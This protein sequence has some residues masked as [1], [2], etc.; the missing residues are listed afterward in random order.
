M[1]KHI[2]FQIVFTIFAGSAYAE[3]T[4]ATFAQK[5][6]D[7]PNQASPDGW[8]IS[9]EGKTGKGNAADKRI[10][11]GTESKYTNKK[12]GLDI[13]TGES[14]SG[15]ESATISVG[16]ETYKRQ[17]KNV[18]KGIDENDAVNVSQL[19]GLKTYTDNQTS[20]I[21]DAAV[22]ESKTYTDNQ[23]S[24][25]KDAAVTE[26]KAYTDNQTSGIKDAAV[27]ES[28]A[29]TDR[30]ISTLNFDGSQTLKKANDYTD[31]RFNQLDKKIDRGLA[32]SAALSMLFQPY[33]VGKFNLTAGVGGHG[34]ETAIAVGSGYR[35]DENKAIKAGVSSSTS[36]SSKLTYGASV[37]FEW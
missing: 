36:S 13:F 32:S 14:V 8:T 19:K 37:N 28:N 3:S 25:I 21:K 26:S 12:T 20:G 6:G 16:N 24:G 2:I 29:Y 1:K 22:T 11:I 9:Q 17:I 30:R 33:G 31:K 34:S 18:E 35:F 23:T 27:T 15:S 5:S 10:S 4:G 7:M